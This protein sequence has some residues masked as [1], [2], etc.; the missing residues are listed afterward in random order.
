[1]WLLIRCVIYDSRLIQSVSESK[2]FILFVL[3]ILGVFNSKY[4]EI[5]SRTAGCVAECIFSRATARVLMT[6]QLFHDWPDSHMTTSPMLKSRP[7]SRPTSGCNEHVSERIK[8]QLCLSTASPP[9]NWIKY[10]PL[11]TD[12]DRL[13]ERVLVRLFTNGNLIQFWL[14]YQ[15]A[16]WRKS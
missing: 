10:L 1:M 3:K 12:C 14:Y 9:Y 4:R 15:S 11:L 16:D 7:N 8:T 2:S 13:L 6:T 5:D